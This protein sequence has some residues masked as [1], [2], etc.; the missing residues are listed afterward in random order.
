MIETMTRP[1]PG[2]RLDCGDVLVGMPAGSVGTGYARTD[3]GRTICYF[4]AEAEERAAFGEPARKVYT[5][6]VDTTGSQLQTWS[7]GN[8]ARVVRH[9]V[10]RSGVH[11]WGFVTND[12]RYWY[13]RNAGPG[14]VVTVRRSV[15]V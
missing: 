3:D 2:D 5:A 7:G 10:S 1:M 6:Y 13:G 14:M 15:R 11:S 8:L 12:A 9:T 4:H